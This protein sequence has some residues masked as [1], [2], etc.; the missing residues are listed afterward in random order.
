MGLEN[1]GLQDP[2]QQKNATVYCAQTEE[3]VR[4]Q[5]TTDS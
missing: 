5:L 4:E 1:E 2:Q 3:E